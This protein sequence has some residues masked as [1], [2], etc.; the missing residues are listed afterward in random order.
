MKLQKFSLPVGCSLMTQHVLNF[1]HL[2]SID[3]QPSLRYD[4]ASWSNFSLFYYPSYISM[5]R[6]SHLL[7]SV[8]QHDA[9]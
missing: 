3:M 8:D 2:C 1:P 5:A 6:K 4:T 7:C 9:G